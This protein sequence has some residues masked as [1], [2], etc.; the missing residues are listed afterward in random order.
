M[1][2]WEEGEVSFEGVM[3]WQ[4]PADWS[5][6]C[7]MCSKH[8]KHFSTS[9]KAPQTIFQNRPDQSL[10]QSHKD[11][12]C[13]SVTCRSSCTYPVCEGGCSWVWT[14]SLL[15][16]IRAHYSPWGENIWD[17]EEAKNNTTWSNVC[18]KEPDGSR[19]GK[20]HIWQCK[21]SPDVNPEYRS[22]VWV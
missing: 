16:C 20:Q 2:R 7:H 14:T 10:K 21:C 22:E 5:I 9:S 4:A 19:H 15:N 17:E 6:D 12:I 1:E 13:V 11:N 18:F 3:S 8:W